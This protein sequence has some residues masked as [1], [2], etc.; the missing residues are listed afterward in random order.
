MAAGYGKVDVINVLLD[1][2]ADIEA[3]DREGWT[4]LHLAASTG[5]CDAVCMYVCMCLCMYIE[6]CDREGWTAMHLAA[7]T[8]VCDAVCMCV[9]IYLC[10]YTFKCVQRVDAHTYI[11][12][13]TYRTHLDHVYRSCICIYIRTYSHTHM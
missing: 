3:R 1:A 2:G 4:A 13:H 9:C 6:A 5:E 12:T 10:I 11:H 8:G 7:S